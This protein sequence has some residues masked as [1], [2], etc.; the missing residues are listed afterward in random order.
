M[1]DARGL[2]P[3]IAI[4]LEER[5]TKAGFVDVVVQVTKFPINHGGKAG[6]LSWGDYRRGYLSLRPVMAKIN[7]AWENEEA[8]T[9]HIDSCGEEAKRSETC[10]DFYSIYARKPQQHQ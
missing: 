3:M 9:A 6:K 4:E 8:Y 10:M 1:S 7:P 5:L 2:P